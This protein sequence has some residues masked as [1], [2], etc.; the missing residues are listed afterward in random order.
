M[1]LNEIPRR[2]LGKM[3]HEV[4]ILLSKILPE[5]GRVYTMHSIG[6]NRH[7]LHISTNAFRAFLESIKDKNIVRL[8]NWE[9]SKNFVCL[10][11]DDVA[12]SF[13]YNAFPLLKHYKMPFTVFVSCSLLDKNKYLTT[14]MLREIAAC[15]LC[16]VGS[17]GFEHSYFRNF[18]YKEA[19][20]DLKSSK[21]VLEN[22]VGREVSVYAFPYGSLYACGFSRKN[23]IREYYKYGFGTIKAPINKWCV[24]PK[25]YLPRIS[26]LEELK[27]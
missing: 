27:G 2:L 19:T 12:S 9:K 1:R 23:L 15:E 7:A 21:R 3:I 13:Y 16:T 14:E 22:L 20:S 26:V 5:K 25:Y 10:T 11:F 24:L 18:N 6:D 17:H 4:I 8:E